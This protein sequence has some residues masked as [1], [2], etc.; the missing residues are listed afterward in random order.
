MNRLVYVGDIMEREKA[1][2]EPDDLKDALRYFKEK[3]GVEAELVEVAD[4]IIPVLKDII[5]A[6]IELLPH[7]GISGWE[8]R[9]SSP[10]WQAQENVR[11]RLTVTMPENAYNQNPAVTSNPTK[12]SLQKSMIKTRG[13]RIDELAGTGSYRKI[14]NI[15]RGEGFKVCHMTVARRLWEK[16]FES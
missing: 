15:L 9:L 8:I 13:E 6:G 3:T 5:P 11:H 16:T 14:A 2:V 10:L 12:S 1:F 7:G 4:K